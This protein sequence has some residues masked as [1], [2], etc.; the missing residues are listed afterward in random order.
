MKPNILTALAKILTHG[1]HRETTARDLL[2][3]SARLG[4]DE[5]ILL[6]I[7]EAIKLR[8][9][10]TSKMVA[11]IYQQRFRSMV[12]R[13]HPAAV[14]LQGQKI[15]S[16]GQ[17]RH[18]LELYESAVTMNAESFQMIGG[19]G[20]ADIWRAIGVLRAKN[21]DRKGAEAAIRA[22]AL[23]YDD[24]ASLFQLAK[25]FMSPS[26]AE[27]ESFMLKAAA[28]GVAK[29]AHELGLLYFKQSQGK[30]SV[31]DRAQSSEPNG[32]NASGHIQSPE[33]GM[34]YEKD[35]A[36]AKQ[37]RLEAREWFHV[38]AES[39]I[40]GSQ[41]YLALL[42]REF[43]KLEDGR[44]W[45]LSAGKREDFYSKENEGWSKVIEYF[46]TRWDDS[47]YNLESIDVEKTR[48]SGRIHAN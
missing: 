2:F 6:V 7:K 21:G 12:Q 45:L 37:K 44:Q 46:V 1:G 39:G 10:T 25:T 20:G 18:A 27:Y 22:A 17:H 48:R 30:I 23:Q 5:A 36:T 15:E 24:P 3:A 33:R 11:V 8:N 47:N 32:S 38:G 41:V 16:E 34:R 43:G 31:I 28:S 9:L 19:I 4:D 26:L 40:I 42:L 13:K 29:A 14:Y 35:S